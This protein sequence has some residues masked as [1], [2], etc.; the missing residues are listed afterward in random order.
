LKG[1]RSG[2]ICENLSKKKL[3]IKKK[4]GRRNPLLCTSL[5]GLRLIGT[6]GYLKRGNTRAHGTRQDL[7]DAKTGFCK[8]LGVS[9]HNSS[10]SQQACREIFPAILESYET[11][12]DCAARA[13]KI[14]AEIGR[15][16]QAKI[17]AH[18]HGC[19]QR[20][21]TCTTSPLP[22]ATATRSQIARRRRSEFRDQRLTGTSPAL[23]T[24]PM[25]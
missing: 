7:L 11:G 3:K 10:S 14:R 4:I 13:R 23:S 12:K 25:M 8:G 16:R 21:V 2:R 1:Y 17:R 18:G 9:S 15:T 5:H 24:P 19:G 20:P 22:L 6:P